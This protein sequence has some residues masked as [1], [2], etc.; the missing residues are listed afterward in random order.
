MDYDVVIIGGGLAGIASMH[1]L[2]KYSDLKVL[3]VEKN[4]VLGGNVRDISYNNNTFDYGSI[5][6]FDYYNSFF[7]MVN[8][9]NVPYSFH[10]SC[11]KLIHS[12]NEPKYIPLQYDYNITSIKSFL[13]NLFSDTSYYNIKLHNKNACD[14]I[15]KNSYTDH[16]LYSYTYG[17]CDQVLESI[18]YPVNELLL[19]TSGKERIVH[20]GLKHILDQL[21]STIKPHNKILFSTTINSIESFYINK[22]LLINDQI[23][24][25]NHVILANPFGNL[26][27]Q[28]IQYSLNVP[29]V[30][31]PYYTKYYAFVVEIDDYT[32]LPNADCTLELIENISYTVT[33][34][35]FGKTLGINNIVIIYIRDNTNNG[36][37]SNESSLLNDI[38]LPLCLKDIN[39]TKIIKTDYFEHTMPILPYDALR[40]LYTTNSHNNV[41][42]AGQYLGHPSMETAVYTGMKAAATIL[43]QSE[44]FANK[45]NSLERQRKL[46]YLISHFS[47][48]LFFIILIIY[49]FYIKCLNHPEKL[50][51]GLTS[52]LP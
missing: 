16:Y 29:S 31:I 25:T 14:L 30:N 7:E 37:L 33:A 20:G 51:S 34:C 22:T 17:T 27:Q 15:S 26:H 35:A 23:I 21:M 41:H 19:F 13:T 39:I 5:E 38:P 32:K 52:L 47:V 43:G 45:I 44:Q 28:N 9:I 49:T 3:L 12:K 6:I 1:Y 48:I 40:N 50:F 46:S 2:N 11:N 18:A 8:D 36:R 24:S 10:R 4:N 42:Y